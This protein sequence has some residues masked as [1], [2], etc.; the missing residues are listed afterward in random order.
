MDDKVSTTVAEKRMRAELH[1]VREENARLAQRV[2]SFEA[3]I[4]ALQDAHE[5]TQG[6]VAQNNDAL[7]RRVAASEA[8]I[9]E[10]Q[11]ANAVSEAM[12]T[13]MAREYHNLEQIV[14]KHLGGKVQDELAAMRRRSKQLR[15]YVC[16]CLSRFVTDYC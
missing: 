16:A 5:T 3:R 9:A 1:S 12:A 8:V 15:R 4:T 2:D 13:A 14:E 11:Q 7:S 10:L 6:L